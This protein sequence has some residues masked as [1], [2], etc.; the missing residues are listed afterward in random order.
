[1]SFLATVSSRRILSFIL[2]GNHI[3]QKNIAFLKCCHHYYS[4]IRVRGNDQNTEC[5]RFRRWKLCGLVVPKIIRAERSVL[6]SIAAETSTF[7]VRFRRSCKRASPHQQLHSIK[8]P[9]CDLRI[10]SI[11]SRLWYLVPR[12]HSTQARIKNSKHF[13]QEP[14]TSS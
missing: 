1:M 4:V 5:S 7:E 10:S 12:F 6:R 11:N 8:Y 14:S 9:R 13:G 3:G 2:V